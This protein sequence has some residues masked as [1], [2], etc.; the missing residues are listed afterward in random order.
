MALS[1]RLGARAALISAAIAALIGGVLVAPAAHAATPADVPLITSGT[2]SWKYLEDNTDPAGSN[3][4]TLV[5]TKAGFDDSAW[6]TGSGSFGHKNGTTSGMGG[7]HAVNTLLTRYIPGQTNNVQTYFFRSTFTLTQAQIDQLNV[8]QGTVTYDDGLRIF[9]NG[10][11]VAGYEDANIT[12]NVQYGGSNG[13]DP[14][15]STFTV[16]PGVLQAGS[17]TIAVALYQCD[18]GSSDIFFNMT[19]LVAKFMPDSA[20]ITDVVLGIGSNEAERNLAWYSDINVDQ[21]AQVVKKPAGTVTEFPVAGAQAFAATRGG[22]TDGQ[23]SQRTTITGLEAN[24]E[25]LYRVG[26]DAMGWSDTYAFA[27]GA[28][29]GDY[30]FLF[31]GDPQIGA[32]GN[33]PNDRTGWINTLNTAEAAFPSSEFIFSAGDQVENAPNETQYEAFLAPEQLRRLPLVPVNGNHDVGSKAYEQHFHTPNWDPTYGAA[34]SSSASGGNYWFKYNGTLYVILNSNSRDHAS[35]KAYMEKIVSEQG[36]DVKWKVLAFHHSIYS[37]ASHTDDSDIIDR[38]VNMPQTISDLGFDLVLMGHDHSY[39]RSWLL[40]GSGTSVEVGSSAQEQVTAN[41]A[42]VLYV[43]ANSASGSKYYAV[44]APNAPF[45]AV[46]NQENKRN[47]SNVEVT[48]AAITVTTY[49][50]DDNTVVDKVELTRA[51]VTAPVLTVPAGTEVAYGSSFDPLTGVSATDGVDGDLTSAI[52]VTGTVNT[53]VLGDY[54]LTYAVADAAGNSATQTRTVKVVEATLTSAK[55]VV[56][57]SARVGQ[58]L[59]AQPGTWSQ[60]ATLTYAWTAN[61]AAIPGAT[62]A[63]LAVTADLVGK[64]VAVSVTGTLTGHTTVTQASDAIAVTNGVLVPG[65]VTVT[66]SAKV[67]GTLTAK[68]VGWPAGMALRYVWTANGATIAGGT[69]AT[70]KLT[71]ALAGKLVRVSVTGSRSGYSPATSASAAKTVTKASLKSV[72]PRI[73]G[74]AKVSRTLKVKAGKWTAGTKLTYRW[75]AN[76]KAIKGATKSSVKLSKAT[77]GK[78]ITVTVTGKKAGYVTKAVSSKATKKVAKR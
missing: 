36:A 5:W 34:S 27:T 17:N 44:K 62:S 74:T 54:N 65:K 38:R 56:T 23:Y 73:T 18:S 55:P 11:K 71:P 50:S 69:K 47:Y 25:Y 29:S 26:S 35:H 53:S 75:Y 16:S 41:P 72:K 60:G 7:G 49:R 1:T 57:G 6:K 68:A 42:E 66:G 13:A 20:T 52:T 45:A 2:T 67:G 39:T 33:V 43:T 64:T 78:R 58:T 31:V 24:T 40:D 19:S 28:L 22:T 61:N 77:R 48:D 59:T 14:D 70:L 76:G 37:V 4:D 32:S 9:V 15:T 10:Q 12:Q 3:A 21:V 46:I 8:L 51:D 63:T 30:N